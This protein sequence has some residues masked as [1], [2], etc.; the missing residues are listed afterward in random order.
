MKEMMKDKEWSRF[1]PQ[2]SREDQQATPT[3]QY[4]FA[5]DCVELLSQRALLMGKQLCR[6]IFCRG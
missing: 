4:W 6:Y 1:M 5:W 2:F 3:A